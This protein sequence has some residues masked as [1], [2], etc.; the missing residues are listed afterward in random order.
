M[1]IGGREWVEPGG[2]GLPLPLLK[3]GGGPRRVA[4]GVS[5]IENVFVS[6]LRSVGVVIEEGGKEGGEDEEDGD[7]GLV[8]EEEKEGGEDLGDK[9][10]IVVSRV[11]RGGRNPVA[12]PAD[13]PLFKEVPAVVVADMNAVTAAAVEVACGE[14]DDDDDDL[15]EE[16][17]GIRLRR[18]LPFGETAG[19]KT[20]FDVLV[21]DRGA[22]TLCILVI[23][24]QSAAL[25]YLYSVCFGGRQQPGQPGFL[26]AVSGD[27]SSLGLIFAHLQ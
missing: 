8:E 16:T 18:S 9:V 21:G 19:T 15:R 26:Q 11:T 10:M 25:I 3:L 17:G 2:G 20:D 1:G 13:A 6:T 22:T 14:S 4:N 7:V 27:A 12:A 23:A 24:Y 5:A